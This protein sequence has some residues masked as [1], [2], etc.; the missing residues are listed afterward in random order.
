MMD[1]SPLL[2]MQL[3]NMH[4]SSVLANYQRLLGEHAEP[5][6]YLSDLISLEAAKRQGSSD[7]LRERTARD[8]RC[9]AHHL[10]RRGARST[11]LR[12]LDAHGSSRARA[13]HG[14]ES[15]VHAALVPRRSFVGYERQ[16]HVAPAHD[17]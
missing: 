15:P 6:P 7:A 5:L 12:C 2:E 1:S 17:L 16:K 13:R 14:T 10:H 11:R 8:G 4:L 3:R 9:H